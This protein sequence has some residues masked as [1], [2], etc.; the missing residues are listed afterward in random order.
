MRAR[1]LQKAPLFASRPPIAARQKALLAIPCPLLFLQHAH[2]RTRDFC[3]TRSTRT[4]A[5]SS[6]ICYHYPCTDGIFAALAGHLHHKQRGKPVRFVPLTVFKA[7]T[8]ADLAL[9]VR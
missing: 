7:P 9:Q 2:T 1:I 5:M 8:V 4:H 3:S 6:V